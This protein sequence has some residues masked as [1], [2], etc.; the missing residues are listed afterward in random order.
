MK[1]QCHG[2]EQL[3]KLLLEQPENKRKIFSKP[4]N[5]K[6]IFNTHPF[7]LRLFY[8]SVKFYATNFWIQVPKSSSSQ[9]F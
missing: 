7:V 1:P 2:L 5:F 8:Q 4:S 9:Y 6:R 3:P